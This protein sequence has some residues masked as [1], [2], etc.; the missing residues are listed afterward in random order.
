[1]RKP[2]IAL[3]IGLVAL[4]GLATGVAAQPAIPAYVKAAVADPGRSEMMRSRDAARKP[5]ALLAFSGI[6]PGDKVGDLI[7]GGGYFTGLF[8]LVVGPAGHV[9][10]IWP[11]EYAKEDAEETKGLRNGMTDP[12][13]ANVTILIQPAAAFAAPESLDLVWTSQNYHDYPDPFMGP[14]NPAVLDKAVY[15]ALKPGGVFMVVDHVAA[16]GSGMRDTNTLHRIDPAI[17]KAQVTAAG[18]V[19][20]GESMVLH[21]AEDPH[22]ALVFD[23]SIRGH[24]DQFV[25]KFRKP[26]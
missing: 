25:Y 11:K 21:N 23:K 9:Y 20:E 6:K 24:T 15:A 17:V 3:A 14:T 19:Y 13:F 7:P 5:A 18:F 8:S 2:I 22:T 26:G 1:V 4:S 10:S 16:A 12:R